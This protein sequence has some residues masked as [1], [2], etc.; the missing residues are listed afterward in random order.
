MHQ[1]FVA[2]VYLPTPKETYTTFVEKW[3]QTQPRYVRYVQTQW[4][5]TL[6][7]CTI[8]LCDVPLQGIHTNN[9]I[10]SW[11]QN[12]KYHF[13]NRA[14]RLLPK[15]LIHTLVFDVVPDFQQSVM[16]TQLGFQGQA[17]T[18][19]QGIAKGEANKYTDND[20]ED[21]GVNIWAMTDTQVRLISV[22]TQNQNA[23]THL[24]SM[25]SI[26]LLP[27]NLPP[28]TYTSPL[29]NDIR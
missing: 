19:F 16:A 23:N 9:F 1:E 5:K 14:I 21:M 15:E 18:K 13:L 28:T 7:K 11:H 29:A 12:L 10:E 6:D 24:H 8:G 2:I 4:G 27:P 22:N 3:Y 17:R 20:L 26:P 25:K